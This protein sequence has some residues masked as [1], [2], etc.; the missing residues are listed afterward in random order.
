MLDAANGA[1]LATTPLR[2]EPAALAMDARRHR[3]LVLSGTT[4]SASVL[5]AVDGRVLATFPLDGPSGQGLSAAMDSARGVAYAGG[6][7]TSQAGSTVTVSGRI[8]LLDTGTWRTLR[9]VTLRT[10]P[11]QLALDAP[12]G[13]LFALSAGG[14]SSL[15]MLDARTLRMLRTIPVRAEAAGI[16]VDESRHLAFVV[17]TNGYLTVIDARTGVA[18]RSRAVGA[19]P[20]QVAID[21]PR[22]RLLILGGHL[23]RGTLSLVDEGTLQV[24]RS[25][26]LNGSTLSV[27]G[28]SGTAF[29]GS[30]RGGNGLW[31]SAPRWLRPLARIEPPRT[32]VRMVRSDL[33]GH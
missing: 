11:D 33:G 5:S 27:D 2:A 24:L 16:A 15:T 23:G 21:G 28:R 18:L 9:A 17:H 6:R 13:H 31:F 30:V 29:V 7:R 32:C 26:P 19:L 8:R 14:Q 20:Q 1:L 4:G 22:H 12:L 10:Y 25:I 3:V